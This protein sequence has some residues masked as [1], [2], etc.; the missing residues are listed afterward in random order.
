MKKP[1][2]RFLALWAATLPLLFTGCG[3]DE[4]PKTNDPGIIIEIPEIPDD[5]IPSKPC[6][7]LYDNINEMFVGSVNNKLVHPELFSDT[8][9]KQIVLKEASEVYVTF[10]SSD[11]SFNNTFGWY[12]YEESNPPQFGSEISWKILFP[13]VSEDVLD[14]GDRLQLGS[15][16]F[17]AGT[18]IGFFLIMQGWEDGMVKSKGKT[19]HF[20]DSRLNPNQNQQH[21]LFKEEECGDIVLSFEDKPVDNF[22]DKDFNDIIFTITD[23]NEELTTT[24][25]DLAKIVVK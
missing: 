15:D 19:I 24:A 11:A 9:L 5:I 23:N 25:F 20:T 18:V 13:N 17:P 6:E 12:A 10:I 14:E 3:P 21:V 7:T 2:P 16:E 4:T 8:V 22:S 1:Q